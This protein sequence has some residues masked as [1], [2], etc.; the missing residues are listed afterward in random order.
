MKSV[1]IVDFGYPIKFT[2]IDSY[3]QEMAPKLD[4][5]FYRM[6]YGKYYLLFKSVMLL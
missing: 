6:V 4:K 3:N 5:H 1:G 2:P